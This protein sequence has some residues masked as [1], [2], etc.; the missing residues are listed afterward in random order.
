[1]VTPAHLN[2]PPVFTGVRDGFSALAWLVA[3]NRYFNLAKIKDDERT[4][5][6]LSYLASPGPARWFDGCGLADTCNFK[7]EFTPAFK[8]EY[9]P[10][11]FAGACRR[12]LTNLRMTTNFSTY[13]TTFK[14]LLG[15]LLG[16]AATE[17]AQT[18]VNEFAQTSFIDNCP[19]VLQQMIEGHLIQNPN[20]TL[21]QVFQYAQEMDRIYSFKPDT[22]PKT[23]SSVIASAPIISSLTPSSSSSQATVMEVD[24]IQVALNNINRRFNQLEKNM[25]RNNTYNHT[26]HSN[27]ANNRNNNG[28]PSPLSPEDREWC[29]QTIAKVDGFIK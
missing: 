19:L 29:K 1:M 10:N 24:H 14:E 13:L 20:T 17:A 7:S 18:T 22:G 2:P 21:V 28:H 15:A 8:L 4:P 16:Y 9:I 6:A 25:G 27:Y 11:N 12:H 3:V 5:H 23:N 26:N